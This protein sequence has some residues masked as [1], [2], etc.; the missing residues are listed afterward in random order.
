MEE[1][2]IR[3]MSNSKKRYASLTLGEDELL[4][5]AFKNILVYMIKAIDLIKKKIRSKCLGGCRR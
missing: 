1:K 3:S 2:L 4:A 5:V